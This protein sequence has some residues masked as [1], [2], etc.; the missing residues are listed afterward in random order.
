M[1]NAAVLAVEER[2][3]KGGIDG[4]QISL[5]IEDDRDDPDKALVA[6][7]NL[8]RS[9]VLAVIGHYSSSAIQATLPHYAKAGLP[10][11]SPA[12]ALTHIQAG[13]RRQSVDS[14]GGLSAGGD[15]TQS[16]HLRP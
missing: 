1:L 7:E 10:L 6:S 3:Q 16:E 8:I 4:K 11:I 5:H 13:C 2:N 14:P 15:C 9:D 12:V